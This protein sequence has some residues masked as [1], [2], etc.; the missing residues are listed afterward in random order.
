MREFLRGVGTLGR[1]FSYWRRRPGLMALGLVPAAIV[2]LI[3]LAGLIALAASLPGL[4]EAMTPFA[5]GW[6][7][8]WAT[9]IRIAAG[10]AVMGAALVL[11]AVS[12]TA[13]TLIVGEPFYERIWRAVE[14]EHDPES[15]DIDVGYGFWASVRDG[16][17][18]LLRGIGIA[19]V[20]AL[21]GFIPV[22]GSVL[23]LVFGVCFTGW[24]LA[25]ELSSRAL[26]ARGIHHRERQRTRSHHRAR[27][28][29]FGVATQLC[30]MLPL[31]AVITMPAAV[32]GSTLLARSLRSSPSP[33]TTAPRNEE[34]T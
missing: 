13:V 33:G 2:S 31:G 20:A 8:L 15:N 18:L 1:G 34:P 27:V 5:T 30:F 32:A 10:T 29:G 11:I 21:L 3:L 26:S 4:T 17:S 12:F 28:L 23:S 19:L 25:D 6:P 16:L 14:L 9:V 24:L 7:T 22:V